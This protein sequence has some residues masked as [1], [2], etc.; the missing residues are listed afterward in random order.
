LSR[1]PLES[2]RIRIRA[3]PARASLVR[4]LGA[5]TSRRGGCA[6]DAEGCS[7]A[8]GR[9][10]RAMRNASSERGAGNTVPAT[11]RHGKEPHHV[12]LECPHYTGAGSRDERVVCGNAVAGRGQPGV[13][14]QRGA[15]VGP[16]RRGCPH[17]QLVS[18][19]RS[20]PTC[21]VGLLAGDET[22]QRGERCSAKTTPPTN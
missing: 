8:M 20:P 22:A 5:T 4:A 16:L 14:P 18:C 6:M 2:A 13:L 12:Y 17:P 11:R 7:N 3:G 21:S 1:D 9:M 19:P 10:L 15:A